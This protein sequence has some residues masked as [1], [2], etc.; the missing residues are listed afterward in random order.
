LKTLGIAVGALLLGV[1]PAT[2]QVLEL[3]Q[4]RLVEGRRD[5]FVELFEREF[6]ETQEAV[7]MRLAGQFRDLDDPR[8]FTWLREFPDMAARQQRLSSFYSGQVWR[9]HRTAA[10]G[11]IVDSDNV[12]LLKP[13]APGSGLRPGAERAATGAAVPPAGI[14]VA[15]IWR[16]WAEPDAAF[17]AAFEATVRPE[18]EE[19]GLPVIGAYLPVR[20]PNTFPALPVREGEKVFVWITRADSAQA[21]AAAVKRLEARPG[22]KAKVAPL[23]ADRLESPPLVRRLSPTPRS[24][25]R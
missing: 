24:A 12:L 9:T 3:R 14:V 1:A 18:L 25:L 20:E 17:A 7:G 5:A 8:R 19:A 22:W 16:L 15:N 23:L 21:Y 13:A 11:M 2:A 4:Y 6:V 10:N